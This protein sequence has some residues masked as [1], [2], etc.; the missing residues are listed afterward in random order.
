MTL[1][2]F[3]GV[4]ITY[5]D[6][7]LRHQKLNFVAEDVPDLVEL[8]FSISGK[9]LVHNEVSGKL[10]DFA[11]NQQNIIYAPY[12]AGIGQFDPEE[13]YQF[14][15]VHYTTDRFLEL[16]KDSC[17]VLQQFAEKIAKNEVAEI[18]TENRPISFAMH[19]CIREIMD[20]PYTGGLKL[21]FLQSK[22][23]ELL[24]LQAE[25]FEQVMQCTKPLIKSASD[26]ERIHFARTYLLEHA[27][28]PPSLSELSRITG[29]NLHKLK[30]GFKEVYGQTVF[31]YLSD[32]KLHKAKDALNSSTTSIKELA[33]EL[34]YSSVQHFGN[35]FQK[36]FGI[37]PGKMKR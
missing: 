31:G 19:Q 8:H 28:N 1:L 35:A 13:R 27:I 5:G 32:Y 9:G 12:F 23:I 29:L 15:E 33:Y 36:K 4:F 6:M 26:K 16:A 24:V 11:G 17:R 22:C 10:Y 30:N 25:S 34:G 37:P 20:C 2:A 18:G 7:W 21:L 14:F 3:S